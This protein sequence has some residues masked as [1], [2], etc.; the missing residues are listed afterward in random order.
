MFKN[1]KLGKKL[2]LGFAAVLILT[3]IVGFVGW[4]GLGD[5]DDR[6]E[7]ADDVNRIVKSMLESR[8]QEKNY[9]IRS[10][11]KYA[12][13]VSEEIGALKKLAQE[14]KDK[15]KDSMNKQQMDEILSAVDKYEKA[16]TK[17]VEIKEKQKQVD[18]EMVKEARAIEKI[19][20][21]INDSQKQEMAEFLKTA[22]SRVA[23][24]V[25]RSQNANL[26]IQNTLA[27][28]Q[29]EKNFI[30]RGDPKYIEEV[31]K[32]VEEI[33]K[34]SKDLKTQL[35]RAENQ[36]QVDQ[37]IASA[38]SYH[39]AFKKYTDMEKDADQMEKGMVEAARHVE[40]IAGK[41]RTDQK[42]KMQNQVN[43]A[44]GLIMGAALLAIALGS[45]AAFFIAQVITRAMNKGVTF[46]QAVAGGDLTTEIDINQKDEIGILADSLK[47]MASQL[48][49]IVFDVK[50][51]TDNVAAGSQEM[52]ATAEELSQ[53]ATEQAASAEEVSSSMEQMSSN[54]KQNADNALQTEKI[55][56][57]SAEDAK[58][59]GKA[60]AETVSAMKEIAAKI[61]I[62]EEIARQTNLLA[63][64][65]AI[66]AARAGEHGK[67]FAV[68]ASEV[69]KLAERSQTAAA[70]IGKLSTTSVAVAEKAGAMLLQIVPDIQ[71]TA[72]LVQ[73]I[74]A[75]CNEQNSGTEQINKAIQQLDQV[76]Q[77]NASAS[78]EMASTSEE[79]SSQAE[80]LQEAIAFFKVGDGG[81]GRRSQAA[82]NGRAKVSHHVQIAHIAKEG[83][84]K[85]EGEKS[86]QGVISAPALM[87]PEGTERVKGISLD[88][89]RERRG[90]GED[91]EFERY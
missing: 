9:I 21:N 19:C 12:D 72:E 60:V 84:K 64:N 25:T 75:A 34:I 43:M 52:S 83:A 89:K 58:E 7:K 50:A 74:S 76:I 33:V 28:R 80:R 49:E 67:G 63:L 5:V 8:Q 78:E 53:G 66:E 47:Q 13:M 42:E 69:R 2:G 51:S 85:L 37:I 32:G 10:D 17:V 11:K 38:G 27:A 61:S 20:Y 87:A 56:V 36:Q 4:K 29:D 81:N 62:I 39:T 6:V 68:V 18:E 88:L 23:E 40:E 45:F 48:R 3:A 91:E 77:Q 70:E 30:L 44:N 24:T 73:E 54:I 71:K 46:A 1:M 41:T 57:K 55:A 15:F 82:G 31:A 59:G 65:A 86:R 14:T 26:I 16:F 35:A 79:L 90:D 22:D